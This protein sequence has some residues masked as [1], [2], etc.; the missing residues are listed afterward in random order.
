MKAW[1]ERCTN[2]AAVEYVLG[3]DEG[4]AYPIYYVPWMD[5]MKI[6]FTAAG[7]SCVSAWNHTTKVAS[8]NFLMAVSDDQFP[9]QNWDDEIRKIDLL[10][11]E[12]APFT[13]EYALA[14]DQGPTKGLI[15]HPFITRAYMG[16]LAREHGYEGFWYPGYSS[17]RCDDDFTICA[18]M[19]GVVIEAPHIKIEHHHPEYGTRDWDDTYRW[20]HREEAFRIGNEVLARRH[21][22][23]GDGPWR[24]RLP[25]RRIWRLRRL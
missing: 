15:S 8:G 5:P 10:L 25:G 21:R 18:R 13:A 19:D 24:R 12:D 7:N 14:P 23:P 16:R 2:P 17:M 9:C 4:Q 20:Q 3:V 22:V 1:R 11:A 6:I